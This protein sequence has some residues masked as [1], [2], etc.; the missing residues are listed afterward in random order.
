SYA[1]V[2]SNYPG[3]KYPFDDYCG[4]GVAFTICRQLMQDPMPELLELAMIGTIGDMVKV[5]GEGHVIVKRGLAMLN[6]TERPGLRALIKNAGL[7]MGQINE[8][9]IGFDIAPRMN[10]VGRLAN[11]QLVVELLLCDDEERAQK[12]AD[13]VEQLNEKRKELTK[14]VNEASLRQIKANDWQAKK[15]L[16]IYDPTFHEGVLGLVANRVAEQVHKPVVVLTRNDAGIVKGSGRSVP[17]F[18]LFNA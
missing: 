14:E 5:S 1:L 11:A 16:V 13:E 15:T 18:N 7:T 2:H 4:A 17:G 10:A 3:Q 12:I 8:T 9:D 6:Q